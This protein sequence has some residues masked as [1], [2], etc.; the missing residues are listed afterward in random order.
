MYRNKRRR[1]QTDESSDEDDD[2]VI[3]KTYKN[4]INKESFKSNLNKIEGPNARN[5]VILE[6]YRNGY[7]EKINMFLDYKAN[8]K[9]FSKRSFDPLLN[10]CTGGVSVSGILHGPSKGKHAL[11]GE[12][13]AQILPWVQ[14]SHS[15]CTACSM[16]TTGTE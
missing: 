10:A 15:A 9:A 6:T 12:H 11:N 2:A 14:Q 4:N 5:T 13:S 3:L 7:K 8:L 1:I 16:I